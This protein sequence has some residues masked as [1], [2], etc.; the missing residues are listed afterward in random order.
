LTAGRRTPKIPK[1]DRILAVH[2]EAFMP[3]PWLSL[4]SA[5]P[6]LD[7]AVAIGGFT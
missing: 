3:A 5:S 7:M 2:P 4:A 1:V 6:G